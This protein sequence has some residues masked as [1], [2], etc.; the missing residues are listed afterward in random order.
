MGRQ[1]EREFK[2]RGVTYLQADVLAIIDEEDGVNEGEGGGAAA[3]ASDVPTGRKGRHCVHRLLS[4][5][6]LDKHRLD[7]IRSGEQATR[8]QLDA[9][10]VGANHGAWQRLHETYTDPNVKVSGVGGR[11]CLWSKKKY[12]RKTCA[13]DTI[14]ER[15]F[16]CSIV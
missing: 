8:A 16:S 10:E 5:M 6:M 12:L 7:I 4:C 11:S 3:G 1:P 14:P 15:I 13:K 2:F 9:G